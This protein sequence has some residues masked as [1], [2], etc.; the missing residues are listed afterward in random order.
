MTNSLTGS[1][2]ENGKN[3]SDDIQAVCILFNKILSPP[4]PV[5]D[6]VTAGLLQA[7]RDFQQD[8]LSR[9]DGRIDVNGRTWRELTAAAERP[10][11]E[12]TEEIS[13]SVGQGGRN[14]PQDV[15]IIYAL[16]NAILSLPLEVSDQ[17]SA[18]L[19]RAIKDVQKTFM[20]RP[21]GRIDVDGRTWRRLTTPAG[22]SG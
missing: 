1:V 11:I 8:F 6:Q 7:I 21:D 4:L 20:S 14:R 12:G 5:S 9:P 2:G 10:E 13:G 3:R 17:C 22:G 16:F 15:R 19:I 18:E